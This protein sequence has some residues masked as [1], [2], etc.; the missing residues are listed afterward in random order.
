MIIVSEKI[1]DYGKRDLT[2]LDLYCIHSLKEKRHANYHI[3]SHWLINC[4][5]EKENAGNVSRKC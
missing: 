3:E 1:E 2:N 4:F 5:V